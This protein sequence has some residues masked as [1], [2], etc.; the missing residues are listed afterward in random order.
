MGPVES[1]IH[2]ATEIDVACRV[3]GREPASLY[4]TVFT[5]GCVLGEGED[6]GSERAM[7]QAGPSAALQ[8]HGMMERWADLPPAARELAKPYRAL[9]ESY[10]PDHARYLALH[11]GH[12]LHLRRDE[13]S[14][15]TGG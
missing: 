8:W 6:A 10:E 9:Y 12:L 2:Q 11:A 14:F 15:V 13:R 5:L 1:A 4:R 3:A 7:A